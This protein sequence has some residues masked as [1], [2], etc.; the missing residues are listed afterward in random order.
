MIN[1]KQLKYLVIIALTAASFA[2]CDDVRRTPGTIYMPDMAYSRAYET[3]AERDTAAFTKSVDASGMKIYFDNL[4]VKGTLSRSAPAFAWTIAQ[5]AAGDTINYFAS[6]A[7]PNPTPMLNAAQF[8][9]AE[10][11]YLI[12][13]GIC[14]GTKLD[15]NGPLWKDGAG[16]YPAAPKNLIGLE[17]PAGQM[18]YSIQY[19]KNK[20]G[21]YASQLT[22]NQRWS[23][24]HYIMI[25]KNKEP[26]PTKATATDS[27][28]AKKTTAVVDTMKTVKP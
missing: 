8:V 2:A 1:M 23:I 13:C 22:T 19:G 20:M 17:M 6:K 21:S 28:A 15:G 14:H 10:R 3:Y 18:F 26:D 16:P 7:V 25:K 12:N 5:D 27:L 11:Q 4:P 9:E 24:I